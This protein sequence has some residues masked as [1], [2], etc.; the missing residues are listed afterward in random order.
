MRFLQGVLECESSS[1]QREQKRGE[2][3]FKS[4]TVLMAAMQQG[5]TKCPASVTGFKSD[6]KYQTT[7][8][9]CICNLSVMQQQLQCVLLNDQSTQM[10][11]AE[12]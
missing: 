11:W 8:G 3:F 4:K 1:V 6:N 12:T 10:G 5:N 7:A 2:A 9:K